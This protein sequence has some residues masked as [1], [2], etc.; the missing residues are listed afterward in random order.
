[1]N[2]QKI[3][4]GVFI[5]AYQQYLTVDCGLVIMFYFDIKRFVHSSFLGYCPIYS[6]NKAKNDYSKHCANQTPCNCSSGYLSTEAY[7]CKNFLTSL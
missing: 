6:E 3:H 1:M 7:K 5:R 4:R 2:M